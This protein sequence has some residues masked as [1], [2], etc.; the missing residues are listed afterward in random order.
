[1]PMIRYSSKTIAWNL[2]LIATGSLISAIAINGV[3]VPGKFLSGG[4]AGLSLVIHYLLPAVPVG[5]SVFVLNIPLFLIGWMFVGRRFFLFSL[6]GMGMFSAGLFLPVP[7][8]PLHD[9]ILKA[10]TAGIVSGIGT[11]FL[12]RSLGSGGGL[13]ILSVILLK[14]FSIRI[15]TTFMGFNGI[16][17]GASLFWFDMETVLY[18]VI[19][20][21]VSSQIV[22][23]VVTGLN[24][25]KSAMVISTKSDAIAAAIMNDM[26]RG[27]TIV[28]GEGGYTKKKLRLLYTI[29]TFRELSKFKVLVRRIDPDAFV[30]VS[31]T[32]EVMGRGVGNQPH[33]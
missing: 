32:M 29:I 1:M 22:N 10:L 2:L 9:P 7:P 18:T 24:Q 16:L 23:I 11:G 28:N 13:D 31:E 25:R 19:I 12:L 20:I 27:V 17:M 15:G 26:H 8:L 3:I 5:A 33:W 21:F 14:K 30:V 4:I 6:A